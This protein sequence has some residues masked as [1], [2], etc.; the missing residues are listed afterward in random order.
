LERHTNIRHHHSIE[1]IGK[2]ELTDSQCQKLIGLIGEE[3]ISEAHQ[4]LGAKPVSFA[5]LLRMI[6]KNKILKQL[7]CSDMSV[8]EIARELDVSNMVIYRMLWNGKDFKK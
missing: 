5:K 2:T 8:N 3:L 7:R 1:N 4:L 6:R